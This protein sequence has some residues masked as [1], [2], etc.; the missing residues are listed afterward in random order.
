MAIMK[1]YFAAAIRAGR[2]DAPIYAKIIDHL[3]KH[4]TV[5]SEHFGDNAEVMRKDAHQDEKH[6]HD[7]DMSWLLD[8]DVVVAE[9][10]TP[11]L[12]V[13]YELG[14]AVE[15]KK[16]VLCLY[17]PEKE[18]KLSAMIRGSDAVVEN[19]ESIEEAMH[20]IDAFFK[21]ISFARTQAASQ[22]RT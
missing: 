12:G 9:V 1:I 7:R 13:G 8:S 20:I 2:D 14:R 15:N 17:R 10:T 4:G 18:K 21:R 3:K 16:H 22:H 19:Y 11:S 5:L 6:I